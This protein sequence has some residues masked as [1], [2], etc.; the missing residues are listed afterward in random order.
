MGRVLVVCTG[1]TCRSPMLQALLRARGV[2][3]DS[4]G[5]AAAAGD[6][7]SDGARGAMFRRGLSL[8]D[9]HST[10]VTNRDVSLYAQVWAMTPRHAAALRALGVLAAKLSVVNAE[11]GGV[12]D[13]YGGDDQAYE[14]CAVVLERAADAIA[15]GIR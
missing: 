14:A 1:N 5:T 11:D 7:A 3:V 2:D 9:H 8:D 6:P 13:P 10:P 15:A 12:P 4:A